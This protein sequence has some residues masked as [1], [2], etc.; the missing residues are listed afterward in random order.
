MEI[1][2]KGARSLGVNLAAD[3]IERFQLYWEELVA[4]NRRINLTNI[5]GYQDVQTRHFLDSLTILLAWPR[6]KISSKTSIIDIGTGCGM[7]GIALKI[8]CPEIRLSLL[9]ATRKKV[10]FLE[11]IVGRLQLDGV[12]VIHSRAEEAAHIS[13]YREWFDIVVSR[14]VAQ[15]VS[16]SELALPFCRVGGR[17]I[18]LKKGVLTRELA[19][20]ERAIRLTG[21]RLREVKP[22]EIDILPDQRKLIII[23]KDSPTPG[24][25]P[26]RAGMASKR[27]LE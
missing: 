16:L 1:L 6:D 13:R 5:T 22:V 25:Y 20:A 9:E 11:H 4:W 8:V 14:A 2:E 10:T 12:E 19:R 18:A 26:R 23:D 3:H 7:P 27:P 15:L 17:F 21:G 24:L